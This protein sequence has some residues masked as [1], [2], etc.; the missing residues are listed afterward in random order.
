MTNFLL[1]RH[2]KADVQFK[3]PD[4]LKELLS[5][6]SREV[7]REQPQCVNTFVA[8]YLEAM[9]VTRENALSELP[10]KSPILLLIF[11]HALFTQLPNERAT[12]FSTSA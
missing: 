8:D 2:R 4:G 9:L 6:I 1:H 7:L 10:E 3:Q 12:I 5:D 11:P